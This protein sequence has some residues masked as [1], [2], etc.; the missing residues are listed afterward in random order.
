MKK[1]LALILSIVMVLAL[2]AGCGG[3][4]GNYQTFLFDDFALPVAEYRR[5]LLRLEAL[6]EGKY[7]RVLLSHGDGEGVPDMIARVIGVCD[8]ILAGR[9]D[10]Q[11]F[12]FLGETA[13]LAK[14]ADEKGR[15]LDGGA[16]NIVYRMPVD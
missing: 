6:A 2:F 7:G 9:S 8:D 1:T 10:E 3:S 15:R 11:P 4:G 14:A 5:S 16:G 13:L 12:E